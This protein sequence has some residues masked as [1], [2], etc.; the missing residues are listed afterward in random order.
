VIGDGRRIS[1]PP[2]RNGSS[3][4]VPSPEPPIFEILAILY[5]GLVNDMRRS[6]INAYGS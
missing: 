2:R 4:Q 1:R 3:S 5:D 6:F